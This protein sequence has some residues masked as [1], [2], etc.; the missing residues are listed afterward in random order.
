MEAE[1]RREE[2]V[3]QKLVW[4]L[5]LLVLILLWMTC[6]CSNNNSHMISQLPWLH[7]ILMYQWIWF[8]HCVVTFSRIMTQ[9]S[10]SCNVYKRLVFICVHN[11]VQLGLYHSVWAASHCDNICYAWI[12]ITLFKV[13]SVNSGDLQNVAT[14]RCDI[15]INII[16]KQVWY[17]P[18]TYI[19]LSHPS[20]HL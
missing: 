10:I 13:T 5:L 12:H 11:Y 19:M 20:P 4:L 1:L 2:E 17:K 8:V 7:P 14:K 9:R 15:N 18:V 16:T 6:N 3:K